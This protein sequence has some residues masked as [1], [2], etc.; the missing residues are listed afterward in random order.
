MLTTIDGRKIS[1]GL[2]GGKDPGID[3]CGLGE[4][5]EGKALYYGTNPLSTRK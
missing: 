1:P 2:G 5:T 4:H 3:N